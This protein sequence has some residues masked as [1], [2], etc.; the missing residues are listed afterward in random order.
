MLD[1]IT[2]RIVA[3]MLPEKLTG[4]SGAIDQRLPQPGSGSDVI[5]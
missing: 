3:S 4:L 1:A 5:T 2:T